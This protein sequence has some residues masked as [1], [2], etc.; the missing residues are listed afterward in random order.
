M[1]FLNGNKAWKHQLVSLVRAVIILVVTASSICSCRQRTAHSDYSLLD[2]Q[3]RLLSFLRSDT[4][5]V[6]GDSADSLFCCEYIL[7]DDRP[8]F[9]FVFDGGCSSCVSDAID[10]IATV[11]V[12]G[13]NG[14]Y[15]FLFF[16]KSEDNDIFYY[17]LNSY[18]PQLDSIGMPVRCYRMFDR[19]NIPNG[20]YRVN[21]G[22]VTNYMPWHF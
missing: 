13:L 5:N 6:N 15:D 10:F 1:T 14:P 18:L 3:T 4:S 17:Y 12:S 19:E 21:E 2:K 16:S 20:L 11:V 22:N 9:V 7:P 8:S